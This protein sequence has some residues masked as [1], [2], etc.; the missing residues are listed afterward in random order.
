MDSAIHKSM[1]NERYAIDTGDVLKS[2]QT[3]IV[4]INSMNTHIASATDQQS[5]VA[6]QVGGNVVE[7]NESF[8]HSL[9]ILADVHNISQGLDDFAVQLKNATSQFKL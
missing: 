7:M 2:I 3:K 5:V 4:S 8:E 9:A 1:D 6:E